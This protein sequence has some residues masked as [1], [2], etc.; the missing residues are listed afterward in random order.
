MTIGPPP[1]FHETRDILPDGNRRLIG[2]AGR[3][4]SDR[5]VAA[6][7]ARAEARVDALAFHGSVGHDGATSTPDSDQPMRLRPHRGRPYWT[8][9]LERHDLRAATPAAERGPVRDAGPTQ[10]PASRTRARRKWSPLP[11]VH[12]PRHR[13][14]GGTLAMPDSR[15]RRGRTGRALTGSR[16]PASPALHPAGAAWTISQQGAI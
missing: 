12:H 11:R 15:G 3:P 6:A 13:H 5:K 7:P 10:S 9:R 16:S 1:K 2:R 8:S 4:S 14:P